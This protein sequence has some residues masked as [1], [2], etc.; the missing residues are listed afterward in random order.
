MN[1]KMILCYNNL[2]NKTCSYMNVCRYA[3][4]LSEQNISKTRE[5]AYNIIKNKYKLETINLTD[6]KYLLDTL[7]TLSNVCNNCANNLCIGGYNC[8]YGAINKEYCV[9]YDDLINRNCNNNNCDKQHLTKHGLI[10]Y[11]RQKNDKNK[12][13]E[14]IDIF[15]IFTTNTTENEYS[16]DTYDDEEEILEYLDK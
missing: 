2:I 8:K 10:E 7:I 16:S 13:R 6:D 9:C 1:N 15:R 4:S 14:K 5:K 12:D 11:N 3:H